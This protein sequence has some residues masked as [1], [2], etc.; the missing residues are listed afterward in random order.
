MTLFIAVN[1]SA[2]SAKYFSDTFADVVK[3]VNPAVVTITSERMAP[4]VRHH[5]FGGNSNN[6][7]VNLLHNISKCVTEI[8]C[9]LGRQVH[10]KEQSHKY[11]RYRLFHITSFQFNCF[12]A[13]MILC[14]KSFTQLFKINHF[15]YC[16]PGFCTPIR[17][18]SD[19]INTGGKFF[20]FPA[21]TVPTYR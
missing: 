12:T 11:N 3:K 13:S 1:L 15:S 8:L 20:S 9:R 14:K 16:V 10:R 2:Q 19:K 4:L 17:F 6:S 5:S 7:W 18:G 21:E